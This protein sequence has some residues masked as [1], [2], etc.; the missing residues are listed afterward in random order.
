[1]TRITI[2]LTDDEVDYIEREMQSA[3]RS[4]HRAVGASVRA[5]LYAA[6]VDPADTVTVRWAPGT[7]AAMIYGAAIWTAVAT[8][9]VLWV[10]R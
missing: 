6:A 8:A 1:M 10:T 5:K 2:D 9:A 7:A 4:R 3:Q